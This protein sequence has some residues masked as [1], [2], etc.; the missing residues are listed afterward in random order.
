MVHLFLLFWI[1]V[2]ASII[3][4][5]I[6]KYMSSCGNLF[7]ECRS[8]GVMHHFKAD[9]TDT[10]CQDNASQGINWLTVDEFDWYSVIISC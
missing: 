2:A 6:S 5:R 4:G 8:G 9:I 1:F 10:S 3:F 7:G